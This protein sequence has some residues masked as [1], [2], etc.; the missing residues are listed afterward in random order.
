MLRGTPWEKELAA[1]GF[2]NVKV[3]LTTPEIVADIMSGKVAAAYSTSIELDYARH[4]GGFK[5][6]MV[7]GKQIHKLDQYLGASKDSPLIK[8]A[9]WQ[10]AFDVLQQDGTFDRIYT[11]YFGAK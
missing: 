4:I 11:S 8:Q 3:Y 10:Q 7:Y 2:T 5:D 6:A 9:D 1:N